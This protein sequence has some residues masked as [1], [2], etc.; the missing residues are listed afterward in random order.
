MH[1]DP[2]QVRIEASWKAALRDEFA[3]PYFLEIKKALLQAKADGKTVYPPNR[4]LFNAF[5]RTPFNRVRVVILGQDPYHQPGQAMGLSFS[6]PVGVKVPPS[7]NNIY[8]ELARTEPGFVRPSHGDLSA[9]TDQ[10]VLLLNAALTVEAGKAG[11]HSKIGWIPFT[12]AV[13]RRLSEGRE[14][15]IFLLWGNFAKEKAKLIDGQRHHILTA[16]HPSP[17]AGGGFVGCGHFH[18]VNEILRARG[19]TPI[20]WQV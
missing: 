15:L 16:V 4:L 11:S 18:Q 17:L 5:Q 14:G 6:V 1:I 7:L 9:W 8:K 20:N 19:E 13:I 2:E 12:D 3:A 10:G